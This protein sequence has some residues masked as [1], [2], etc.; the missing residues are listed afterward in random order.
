MDYS[1]KEEICKLYDRELALMDVYSDDLNNNE[2]YQDMIQCHK[3]RLQLQGDADLATVYES[4]RGLN[5]PITIDLYF[6]KA[7]EY[8]ADYERMIPLYRHVLNGCIDLWGE[9]GEKTIECKLEIV[10]CLRGLLEKLDESEIEKEEYGSRSKTI[11][12]QILDILEKLVE[13]PHEHTIYDTFIPLLLCDEYTTSGSI[14]R[15]AKVFE[16]WSLTH[17]ITQIKDV[18][19]MKCWIEYTRVLSEIGLLQVAN[20]NADALYKTVEE[21]REEYKDNLSGLIRDLSEIYVTCTLYHKAVEIIENIL[22]SEDLLLDKDDL[23]LLRTQLAHCYSLDGERIKAANL[24]VEL[25]KTID[26]T[27]LPP[28]FKLQFDNIQGAIEGALGDHVQHYHRMVKSFKDS[29]RKYG[30]NDENTILYENNLGEVC[31]DLYN[32]NIGDAED[33][34]NQAEHYLRDALEHSEYSRGK[35]NLFSL[36]IR[37]NLAE[38]VAAKGDFENAIEMMKEVWEITSKALTEDNDETISAKIRY[39]A[40]TLEYQQLMDDVPDWIDEIDTEPLLKD[41][42]EKKA[43]NLGMK[44]WETLDALYWYNRSVQSRELIQYKRDI[45]A[46]EL[47]GPYFTE[48]LKLHKLLFENVSDMVMQ[49]Y[50]IN[51]VAKQNSYMELLELNMTQIFWLIS[52]TS[53]SYDIADIFELV[54]GYKNISFDMQYHKYVNADA[55]SRKTLVEDTTSVS[56]ATMKSIYDSA[57]GRELV[58]REKSYIQSISEK[59]KGTNDVYLDLWQEAQSWFAFIID[60]DGI[61]LKGIDY[62]SDAEIPSIDAE[63]IEPQEQLDDMTYDREGLISA[64]MKIAEQLK[65]VL[66]GYHRVYYNLQKQLLNMPIGN[67]IYIYT[68]IPAVQVPSIDQFIG[69]GSGKK[70]GVAEITYIEDDGSIDYQLVKECVPDH[71]HTADIN[72]IPSKSNAICISGHGIYDNNMELLEGKHNYI[73][74]D[75]GNRIYMADIIGKDMSAIELAVL[76]I[77]QTGIGVIYSNFG[78]YSIG[79]AFMIA[80]VKY[81]VETLWDIT[82]NASIIFEYE[83]FREFCKGTDIVKAYYH[84]LDKLRRFTR[85]DIKEMCR[86]VLRT[87]GDKNIAR[88]LYA[89]LA[90]RQHPYEKEE[91]WAGF[92]LAGR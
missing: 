43:E 44:H 64:A 79:R 25:R 63:N 21:N 41:G 74:L 92:I 37:R 34:L 67:Y 52:N 32:A 35:D 36:L 4:V 83:F 29:S 10:I 1:Q 49:A 13:S 46:D 6:E 17:S 56:E 77:C 27:G 69:S 91:Y 54:A 87:T 48:S 12:S 57:Y 26:E 75:N 76:P 73:S 7:Q 3:R 89:D 31:F 24:I 62:L 50:Y 72:H 90:N 45:Q 5:N 53:V 84:A 19:E 59:L 30:E 61:R 33:Y 55:L 68:S 51:S 38:V 2:K 66:K 39:A 23:F 16:K 18:E 58:P 80:G 8:E 82:Y 20:D 85:E 28:S 88:M 15:A 42:F 81:T 65:E 71:V 47:K 70:T 9:S 22:K 11:H 40:L 60:K 14:T 86:I 78:A